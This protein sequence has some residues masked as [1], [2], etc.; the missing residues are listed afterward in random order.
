MENEHGLDQSDSV[1]GTVPVSCEQSNEPLGSITG[2]KFI[3]Q[4][5]NY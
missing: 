4:L 2:A 5:S 3:E 1:T